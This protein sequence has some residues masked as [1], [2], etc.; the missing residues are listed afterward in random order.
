LTEGA[1]DFGRR[2]IVEVRLVGAAAREVHVIGTHRYQCVIDEGA[3]RSG[4]FRNG[5]SADS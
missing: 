2:R 4:M 5:D 1:I 3:G